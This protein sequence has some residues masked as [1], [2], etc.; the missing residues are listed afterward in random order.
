MCQKDTQ[1]RRGR[2]LHAIPVGGGPFEGL[3]LGGG[4]EP[5]RIGR[6]RH[7]AV[8]VRTTRVVSIATYSAGYL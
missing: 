3:Q 1:R 5:D 6:H 7:G 2:R 4:L 8:T